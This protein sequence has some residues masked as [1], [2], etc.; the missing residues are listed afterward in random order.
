M[1]EAF[2]K[3]P[4]SLFSV[5]GKTA[6]VT[7]ATGGIAAELV[8]KSPPDGYTLLATPG[9]ALGATPHLQKVNFDALRDFAAVASIG[10]FAFLVAAIANRRS[11]R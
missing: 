5:K 7:G 2:L 10:E 8:A 11:A 4:L 9:S 3:D 1:S 6:V